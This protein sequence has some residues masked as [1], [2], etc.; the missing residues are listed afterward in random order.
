MKIALKIICIILASIL[1]VI[2]GCLI[3]YLVVTKDVTL[4]QSKL[5]NMEKTVSFYDSRGNFLFTEGD[6]KQVIE[7][8]DVPNHVKQAFIAVEDKR[9]YSHNGVDNKGLIRAMFNNIKSL[10]FKEGGST[11]SQQLIKNTHLTSQKTIKRKLSEIKLAKKLEKEFS[12]EEIL[13]K[14]L[15]TIYFGDNCYGIASASAHYFGKET[16]DLTI[17]EGAALAG[18]I[19][20]PSNYSPFNDFVKCN[21]RKNVVL[22]QMLKEGYIDDLR[23]NENVNKNIDIQKENES[24]NHYDL[25]YLVKKELNDIISDYPFSTGNIKVYTTLDTSKQNILETTFNDISEVHDKTAILLDND[26]KIQAYLSTCGDIPRQTGSIIKPILVY[27][28]AIENDILYSSSPI[29]DEKTDYNGYSPSNYNDKY[30]GYVT[31][32]ESL[33]KS[34]N[35]CAV[36]I[37][38]YTGVEKSKRYLEKMN[39]PFSENDN[40]LCLA[41]GATEKGVKLSKISSLYNV[42]QNNGYYKEPFSIIKVESQNNGIIYKS[43][44]SKKQVFSHETAHIISDMLEYTVKDGTAKKLSFTNI[45]LCSKTGTVGNANG[46]T[47][48]YNISYNSKY[49]L[50][51][52]YGNKDNSLMDN[53][54]TGGTKPTVTASLIWK[55]IYKETPAPKSYVKATGI[56]ERNIDKIELEE[57]HNLLLASQL[58]PQRYTVKGLFK[59]GKFPQISD[60]F[61]Q[62]KLSDYSI[63]LQD[64][65]VII[66]LD[67]PNYYDCYVYKN[68]NGSKNIIYDTNGK[69]KNI[70]I[71]KTIAPNEEYIYSLVPYFNSNNKIIEGKEIFLEKIKIPSINIEGWWSDEFE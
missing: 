17:N 32:K 2:L 58:A 47:D 25:T 7:I 66:S 40:S 38:N 15:N 44:N 6:K 3:Y 59:N 45:P 5:I 65:S 31:V 24:E 46:N 50:G 9:F 60:R 43:S 54:L 23:Y 42:F 13:E 39:F 35:A 36:K 67:L 29:L 37:F 19:K 20:A 71:D 70:V 30:Y 1:V 34:L 63:N 33:A 61:T 53:S 4:D 28:P 8:D 27:A 41:L 57:G 10:S 21:A 68:C 18:I 11:I 26:G 14:Y 62:P 49:V 22:S 52:W 12:K 56:C 69:E 51:V 16:K 55:E 64:N 48:A